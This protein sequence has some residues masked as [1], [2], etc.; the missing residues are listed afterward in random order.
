MAI[1]SEAAV[2]LNPVSL[3][4]PPALPP[5]LV[6][7]FRS[8]RSFISIQRFQITV[9]GSMP[10]LVILLCMLLSIS[11]ESKLLAMVMA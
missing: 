1:I 6:T 7:M 2:M 9:R 11:A 3:G 4:I 8:E 5:K 10:K